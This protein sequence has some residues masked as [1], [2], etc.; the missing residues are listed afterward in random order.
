MSWLD[1]ASQIL[2]NAPGV[3]PTKPPKGQERAE[4]G[5]L[6]VLSVDDPVLSEKKAELS[7]LVDAV[8][9][10]H[11]FSPAD[12]AEALGVAKQN[13]DGWLIEF[14]LLAAEIPERLPERD[15]RVTCRSC[16]ELASNGRC[17]AAAGGRMPG[18][19]PSYCPVQDVLRRC[20]FFKPKRTEH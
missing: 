2:E 10:Y 17:R 13:L 7:Q 14:R 12:T 18:A 15:D 16:S 5:L 4:K 11:G 8:A 1:R 9:N 20:E 3:E 19:L 6:S